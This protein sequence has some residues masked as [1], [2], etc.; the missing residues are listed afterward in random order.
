[1]PIDIDGLSFEEL[2]DLNQRVV[3]QAHI[4]MMQFNLGQQVSFEHQGGRM[5]ATLVKYNRKTVTVV[6]DNG[7]RWNILPHLLS[8]VKDT[9]SADPHRP[10]KARKKKWLR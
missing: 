1:M 3:A 2:L 8:P 5:L 7:Q 6:T 4:E 9:G 10:A